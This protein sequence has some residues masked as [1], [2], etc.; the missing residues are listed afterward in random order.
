MFHIYTF[1]LSFQSHLG[2]VY[3]EKWLIINFTRIFKDTWRVVQTHQLEL[4]IIWLHNV[5]SWCF[6]AEL[7]PEKIYYCR[8]VW[9]GLWDTFQNKPHR[10]TFWNSTIVFPQICDKLSGTCPK[11]TIVGTLVACASIC[12]L[13]GLDDL[14][15]SQQ[16]Q[17]S[18]D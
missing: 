3:L 2:P 1:L 5:V 18:R 9:F 14:N 8:F 4:A 10:N 17:I 7:L 16:Y 15:K 11:I 6:L 13:G 12:L